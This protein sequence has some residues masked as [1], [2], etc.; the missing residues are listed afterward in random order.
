MGC[1][2]DGNVPSR[3]IRCGEFF[4]LKKDSAPEIYLIVGLFDESVS[5][6]RHLVN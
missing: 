1:C 4:D 5:L 6:V 2:E 3:T